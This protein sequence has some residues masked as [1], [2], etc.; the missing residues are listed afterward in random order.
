MKGLTIPISF[1]PIISVE[2]FR[3]EMQ[4]GSPANIQ[5]HTSSQCNVKF[6]NRKQLVIY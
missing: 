4:E 6:K 2:Y 1:C 5:F 3:S